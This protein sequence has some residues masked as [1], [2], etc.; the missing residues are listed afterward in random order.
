MNGEIEPSLM[1]EEVETE[2]ILA[3]TEA[4]PVTDAEETDIYRDYRC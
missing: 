2:T 1:E 3:E 4:R